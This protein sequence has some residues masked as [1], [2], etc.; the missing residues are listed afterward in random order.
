[1]HRSARQR[2]RQ[3]YKNKQL[4]LGVRNQ[5]L[6]LLPRL[7]VWFCSCFRQIDWFLWVFSSV[8]NLLTLK[9]VLLNFIITIVNC[10]ISIAYIRRW[11]FPN[12]L[13]NWK[14]FPFER[15]RSWKIQ[16]SKL[17]A[18]PKTMH[19]YTFLDCLLSNRR[20]NK[21]SSGLNKVLKCSSNSVY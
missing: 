6:L 21:T 18:Y 4:I 17:L 2:W 7:R 15:E 12:D 1:M 8:Q 14:D 3:T 20:K 10:M 9:S 13:K 19:P 5:R 11:I 16:W